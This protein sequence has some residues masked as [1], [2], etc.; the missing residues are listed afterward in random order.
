MGFLLSSG[1]YNTSQQRPWYRGLCA[2]LP[3]GPMQARLV[4]T[5]LP[6]DKVFMTL[7]MLTYSPHLLFLSSSVLPMFHGQGNSSHGPARIMQQRPLDMLS[8]S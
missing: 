7:S 6:V 3:W 2:V 4:G 8:F 5:T 1:I